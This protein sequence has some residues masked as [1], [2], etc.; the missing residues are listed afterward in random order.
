MQVHARHVNFKYEHLG[1]HVCILTY[2]HAFMLL[3]CVHILIDTIRHLQLHIHVYER[4][5]VSHVT[6]D[7]S[8]LC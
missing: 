3:V 5:S 2:V 6:L 1:M 7:Y 8:M 4:I